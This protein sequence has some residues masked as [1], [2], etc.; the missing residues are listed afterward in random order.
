MATAHSPADMTVSE[1]LYFLGDHAAH[2][3]AR[4]DHQRRQRRAQNMSSA[5]L[6]IGGWR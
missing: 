5:R 1:R 2:V 3:V 4:E 6:M